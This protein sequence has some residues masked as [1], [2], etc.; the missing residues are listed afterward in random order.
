MNEIQ[1]HQRGEK[2]PEHG[3]RNKVVLS[4]IFFLRDAM[5]VVSPLFP[6]LDVKKGGFGASFKHSREVL[7]GGKFAVIVHRPLKMV[8]LFFEEPLRSIKSKVLFPRG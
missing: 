6:D 3:W 5:H 4:D 7:Y 2:I 1:K 8:V